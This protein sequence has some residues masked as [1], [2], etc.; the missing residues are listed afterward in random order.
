ML[1]QHDIQF[2]TNDF[3]QAVFISYRCSCAEGRCG[4][5]LDR[6]VGDGS[7]LFNTHQKHLAKEYT[8][9]I[10]FYPVHSQESFVSI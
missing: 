8:D 4:L 6:S 1:I 3:Y 10:L 9:L 2:Q 7:R 5:A